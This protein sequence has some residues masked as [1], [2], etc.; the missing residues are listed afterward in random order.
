MQGWH[1]QRKGRSEM[2]NSVTMTQEEDNRDYSLAEEQKQARPNIHQ[3]TRKTHPGF[4]S[5]V[6]L[7]GSGTWRQDL[8]IVKWPCSIADHTVTVESPPVRSRNLRKGKYLSPPSKKFAITVN[9]RGR[10]NFTPH[11]TPREQVRA[12]SNTATYVRWPILLSA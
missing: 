3:T 4:T 10:R 12:A 7:H 9:W 1:L 5:D 11:S 2:F 8:N 6:Q